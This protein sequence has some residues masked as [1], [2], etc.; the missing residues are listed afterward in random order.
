MVAFPWYLLALGI[1]LVVV[2]F[3]LAA[4]S[5]WSRSQQRPID[6]RMRDD[7]IIHRLHDRQWASFPNLIIFIGLVCILVSVVWRLAR[8]FV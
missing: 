5:N 1:L 7:E 3:L 6:I 2:G 4:L 8:F